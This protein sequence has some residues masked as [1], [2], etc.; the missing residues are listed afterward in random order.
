MT[1]GREMLSVNDCDSAS[2]VHCVV[3]DAA[4]CSF[5]DLLL[6]IP[7]EVQSSSKS[8]ST[9]TFLPFILLLFIAFWAPRQISELGPS[10][11][12]FSLSLVRTWPVP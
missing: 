7:L 6:E 10:P 8:L 11:D 4:T 3:A 12:T 2:A 5:V 9:F 1:S